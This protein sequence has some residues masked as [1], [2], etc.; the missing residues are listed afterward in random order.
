MKTIGFALALAIAA[1]GCK[2]TPKATTPPPPDKTQKTDDTAKAGDG[3]PCE[4]EIALQ[5]AEDQ[6]D[7]CLKTPREGDTHKCVAK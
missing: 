2:N 6:I 4:Q 1:A 5:C 7:A 3:T